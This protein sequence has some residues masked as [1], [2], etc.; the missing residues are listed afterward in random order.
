LPRAFE[1]ANRI[2]LAAELEVARDPRLIDFDAGAWEGRPI[3]EVAQT[4][5]YKRYLAQPLETPIP[6][7]R[8]RLT[9]VRDR[10]VASVAQV[11]A[12]NE[13]GA[14]IVMV[15][16]ASPLRVLIAHALGMDVAMYH[17]LRLDPCSVSVLEFEGERGV[18]RVLALN[19]IGSNRLPE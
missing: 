1:T 9:E 8:E 16:H 3:A 6:G 4:E 14:H 17:R 15:S 18:P 10:V 12:D 13:L 2:G 5:E 7:G 11:L 19:H